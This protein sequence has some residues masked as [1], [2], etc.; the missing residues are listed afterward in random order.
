MGPK[1]WLNRSSGGGNG[2]YGRSKSA[3]RSRDRSN[4][5][6]GAPHYAAN[7][8]PGEIVDHYMSTQQ[9]NGGGAT[10][11]G[12]GYGGE[13]HEPD[14]G[15]TF[16]TYSMYEA[17]SQSY[18]SG[19]RGGDQ[20][21]SR[22]DVGH[23]S[24]SLSHQHSAFN[25]YPTANNLH[26]EQ[27]DG[28]SVRSRSSRA[29]SGRGSAARS[30]SR[31]RAYAHQ[32]QRRPE[33]DR[34]NIGAHA[35][36][37][38]EQFPY[39][40][41]SHFQSHGRSSSGVDDQSDY[42]FATNIYSQYGGVSVTPSMVSGAQLHQQRTASRSA[43]RGASRSTSRSRQY[44]T[45]PYASARA[46]QSS[47]SGS[48]ESS[49]AGG[50]KLVVQYALVNSDDNDEHGASG[51]AK[52]DGVVKVKA[53]VE[54][55]SLSLEECF[56]IQHQEESR[57]SKTDRIG[58]K[59][60]AREAQKQK[61]IYSHYIS[62]PSDQIDASDAIGIISS[63]I[64]A[65]RALHRTTD[66]KVHKHDKILVTKAQGALGRAVI[67]LGI[68]AGCSQVFG[69]CPAKYHSRV[70]RWGATA[71]DEQEFMT[72]SD[73]LMGAMDIV[74]DIDG[75]CHGDISPAAALTA[76]Q[77][78]GKLVKIFTNGPDGVAC[79]EG[80]SG[81]GYGRRP[82]SPFSRGG[83]NKNL[84]REPPKT[85]YY[86][87]F[88]DMEEDAEGFRS[89]LQ[90][91]F[92]MVTQ[93][94][95]R[96]KKKKAIPLI[97]MEYIEVKFERPPTG[98]FYSSHIEYGRGHGMAT[99]VSS[100][101]HRNRG[102]D[103]KSVKSGRSRSS[104]RSRSRSYADTRDDLDNR[105]RSSSRRVGAAEP[106]DDENEGEKVIERGRSMSRSDRGRGRSLSRPRFLS[107]SRSKSRDRSVASR[108]SR[109][110]YEGD[111]Q[112]VKSGTSTRSM[113]SSR[114]KKDGSGSRGFIKRSLSLTNLR[115]KSINENDHG[116]GVPYEET[117]PWDSGYD[118][119]KKEHGNEYSHH[120]LMRDMSTQ[121]FLLALGKDPETSK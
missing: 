8:G 54:N 121:S 18:R 68:A 94:Y 75:S 89:D 62:P 113:S 16:F 79:A 39:Q 34:D 90:L 53:R 28:K 108:L 47:G 42:T 82:K 48:D 65:Y 25:A 31:S 3:T 35:P 95:V 6:G 52:D 40:S 45:D 10:G 23:P 120:Y 29:S 60:Y 41:Q 20:S 105:S 81:S 119:V 63:Y 72:W 107:R 110:G 114:S 21:R 2:R 32:Q 30:A 116:N 44:D 104:Q 11:G 74:I 51:G 67:E 12:G 14:T 27:L 36:L 9:R 87:I 17:D 57:Q 43:S 80:N 92:D 37:Q 88:T 100:S 115:R 26:V 7:S 99:G 15:P 55:A 73:G 98:S 106:R 5:D 118:C 101:F 102:D 91:L 78:S 49:E 77:M 103:D 61:K 38:R 69:I 59:I 76:N 64:T 46:S 19:R 109:V 13:Y 112:S 111:N 22:V 33:T 71:L 56:D 96:P 24:S 84:R 50:K 117:E 58:R 70:S 93:G 1:G 97:G 86:D 4:D 66:R 83:S 85:S